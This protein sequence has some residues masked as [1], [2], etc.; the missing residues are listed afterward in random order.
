MRTT[1]LVVDDNLNMR[2]VLR[3]HL[4]RFGHRVSEASD[5]SE[6][7]AMLKREQFDIVISDLKMPSMDG[8]Q[9]LAYVRKNHPEALFIMISAHGTIKDA[10]EAMKNG[11]ADYI[12][13]PFN[14]EEIERIISNAEGVI[15]A[16]EEPAAMPDFQA[17]TMIGE[18]SAAN[19]V[20]SLIEKVAP[21]DSTVLILGESGTGKELAARAIHNL[22]SRGKRPFIAVNCA[23]FGAGVLESELFGHEKGAF[24]GASSLR[25]G[26]FEL[27]DGGTL[28]LDEIGELTA[29]I[30]VKFL[31]VLQE[32]RFERVGGVRELSSD[33]RLIAAT[34]K[35]LEEEVEKGAFR[36]DLFY[37][38]NII[39][40]VL[41]PLR[42]RT[43]DIPVLIGHFIAR[44]NVKL[45]TTI[46]GV[47]ERALQTLCAYA[48]P[49]NIRE[50][51]NI[52][53]RCMVL[54]R[55]ATITFNDL[56]P[57][58]SV[59]TI[60]GNEP[61]ADQAAGKNLKQALRTSI[62]YL[63]KD[64]IISAL[65]EEGGNRTNAAKRLGISRKSLQLKMKEYQID[66]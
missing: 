66:V 7:A 18:S 13:K 59:S 49:G 29:D 46:Q 17:K 33:F 14:M 34:N 58:L 26:R 10:V 21:A 40:L 15:D 11:A 62:E 31:R 36:R 50:L 12:T 19:E 1:I 47:H 48:W 20:R 22:S 35:N 61:G 41:P 64:F 37:R 42:Q 27:A 9:L 16:N 52:I 32:R 65:R 30:Q 57:H 6:A 60:R 56:P 28:F 51:E 54:A 3:E 63:E 55:G 45:G 39:P 8:H 5:G 25:A 53:E 4:E 38:L 44:F 23:A 43:S 24:T 2:L